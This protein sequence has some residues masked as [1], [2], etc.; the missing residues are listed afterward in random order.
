MLDFYVP[1]TILSL[2]VPNVPPLFLLLLSSSVISISLSI[3]CFPFSP[4]LITSSAPIYL[5]NMSGKRQRV[6]PICH[7]GFGRL[8]SHFAHS[9]GCRPTTSNVNLST[10]TPL[11]LPLALDTE[12]IISTHDDLPSPFEDTKSSIHRSTAVPGNYI[13][14]THLG[15]STDLTERDVLTPD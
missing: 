14:P 1:T 9:P 5:F 4:F 11:V 12:N 8:S 3:S 15:E 10:T 7:F 13:P 6:C 2:S